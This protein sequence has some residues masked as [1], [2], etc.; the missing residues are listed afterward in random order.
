[1]GARGTCV[2]ARARGFDRRP[3]TRRRLSRRISWSRAA[4]EKRGCL[5]HCSYGC[6]PELLD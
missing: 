5:A 6:Q 1:V 4:R 3:V 2:K